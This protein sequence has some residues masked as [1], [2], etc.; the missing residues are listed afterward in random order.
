MQKASNEWGANCGPGAVAGVLGMTLDDLRP[1]LVD[2][3]QKGYTNPTLMWRILKGLGVRFSYRGGDLGRSNWP[4]FGMARVQWEGPWTQ[5]GVPPAARYR[6]T[7]WVGSHRHD[8]AVSVFDVNCICVG[9]WVTVTEWSEKV[10]PW[11][12]HECEPRASGLW[13]IT[14]AVEITRQ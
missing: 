2:F 11:L 9:G 6:H 14:H 5:P 13:H 12:L 10:V 3:E 1:H 7:H 8:G 4:E